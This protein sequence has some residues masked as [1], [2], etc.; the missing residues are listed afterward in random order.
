[1]ISEDILKQAV[2]RIHSMP[3]LAGCIVGFHGNGMCRACA[4]R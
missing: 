1:M 3:D 2:W 4:G